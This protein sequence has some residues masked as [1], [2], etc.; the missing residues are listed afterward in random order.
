[1]DEFSVKT[2]SGFADAEFQEVREAVMITR[3][4]EFFM[5]PF[6]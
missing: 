1:V 5:R 6:E 4:V 2:R 3:K